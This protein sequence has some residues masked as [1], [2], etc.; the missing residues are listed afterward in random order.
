MVNL[1][2]I[3]WKSIIEDK[4]IW[5]IFVMLSCFISLSNIF[6][7]ENFFNEFKENLNLFDNIS[8][9]WLLF[10]LISFLYFILHYLFVS[11]TVYISVVY[12]LFLYILL[13]F[14]Y[15]PL[16]TALFLA[17]I[18]NI[19]GSLTNYTTTSASVLYENSNVDKKKWYLVSFYISFINFFIWA[20]FMFIWWKYFL[21]L[22]DN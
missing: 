3:S 11:V 6:S 2:I 21:G 19:S 5:N 1:N 4:N 10:L 15:N 14:N 20:I 22:I 13:S 18:S 17:Y 12:E 7:N 8:N 9:K 16:F